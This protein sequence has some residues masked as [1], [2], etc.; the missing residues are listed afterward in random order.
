MRVE[1]SDTGIGIAPE[2]LE[3][4][5]E[6]FAQADGSTTRKYGGTGL[7]LAISRQLVELMG[8]SGRRR[9]RAGQGQHVLVRAARGA[10]AGRRRP[11]RDEEPTLAGLRVLVVD[12]NATSRRILERQL[13]SWQMSCEVADGAGWR[14]GAAAVGRRPPACPSRWRCST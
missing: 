11:R 4:L 9:E 14:H 7:G 1:V 3:Q 5:F 6:P 12:D 2:A 13:S 10:R 8:G